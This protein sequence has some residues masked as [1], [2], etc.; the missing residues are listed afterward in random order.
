MTAPLHAHAVR[1]G[2][3]GRLLVDD[4]DCT[5][6]A[7]SLTA[8]V[9]PNGA[10]KSTLLH[11]IA[12]V[13][14]PDAGTVEFAGADTAGMRRR[15]RARFAALV[16]QQSETVLDLS[17]SDVVLLGRTPHIPLLGAPDGL[18]D[19]IAETALARMGASDLA[20]RR[21]HEL[22]GGERQRVLLARALAQQPT[23]LLADEP[24]NHL[25]IR[26]QLHALA[27]LRSLADGG[28]AVFA[29]LHDLTL[30]ARYA[31]Q[32]IVLDHGR[33]VASGAPAST[34]TPEL[35]AQVY[36][37]RAHVLS[38]PAD[39]SVLIAFSEAEGADDAAVLA[40]GSAPATQPLSDTRLSSERG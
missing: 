28:L 21:F 6:A 27:L 3:D 36:G 34:L 38:H 26:A 33:V 16:E 17:V 2:R 4:V 7:G 10:G 32:V 22:S 24:T 9:G 11:L 30:A 20:G 35:I 31:D 15:E 8:L 13:E 5:V 37:V 40:G 18:D 29:A 12:A 19:A 23:L 25:D 39:G 14:R 1:F